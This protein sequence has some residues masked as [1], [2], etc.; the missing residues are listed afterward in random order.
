MK[1][2]KQLFFKDI[3]S[4]VGEIRLIA[5][6]VALQL[7]YGK[8]KIINEPN[9]LFLKEM[10]R[11]QYFCEQPYNWQNISRKKNDIRY[12]TG[13]LRNRLSNECLEC[14]AYNTLWRNKNIR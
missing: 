10:I 14:P 6:D 2:F 7:Y 11:T 4:P 9:C 12:T 13:L 3:Q 8:V 1:E 5:T